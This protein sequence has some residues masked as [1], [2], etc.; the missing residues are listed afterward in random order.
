MSKANATLTAVTPSATPTEAEI[1]AWEALPRDEQL[2]LLRE[3]LTQPE[4]SMVSSDT[5]N[6]VLAEAR[7]LA[8]ARGG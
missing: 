7:R 6:D 4:C 2:R 5:M 1:R 3:S 8:T